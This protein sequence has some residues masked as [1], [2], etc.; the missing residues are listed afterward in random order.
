GSGGVLGQKPPV[1]FL[2][3]FRIVPEGFRAL[4]GNPDWPIFSS[5]RLRFECKSAAL[6][7]APAPSR[8][9]LLSAVFHREQAGCCTEPFGAAQDQ[10]SS[11][12]QRIVKERNS[13]IL[14]DGFKIDEQIPAANEVHPGK[15]RIVHDI[16]LCEDAHIADHL[17]DPVAVFSL[18]E[19]S[20]KPLRG[21][22]ALDILRIKAIARLGHAQ[23]ADVRSE[24]LNWNLRCF[25]S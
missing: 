6:V 23:I 24:K 9:D 13:L 18:G 5:V 14:K 8:K 11:G 16:V 21:Y 15:R 17:A 1:E 12:T 22:V 19:K 4:Y 20:P 3:R 10:K 25:V 2:L 7:R